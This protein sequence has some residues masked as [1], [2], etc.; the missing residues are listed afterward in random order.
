MTS[1]KQSTACITAWLAL[2]LLPGCGEAQERAKIE[3]EIE[4]RFEQQ[5]AN[6]NLVRQS[7]NVYPV[8][9]SET[10]TVKGKLPESLVKDA[11]VDLVDLKLLMRKV[12]FDPPIDGAAYLFFS[13]TEITN[14]MYAACLADTKQFRDDTAFEKGATFTMSTAAPSLQVRNPGSLWRKGKMPAG[15]EEHPVSYLSTAQGMDFCEWLN[16]RYELDGSFRLPTEQEWLFAAYGEK[17]FYPW[18]NEERNWTGPDTEPV[19][20]RPELKTP[21]GLYGMWGNV[22]ELVL[23]DSNGYGGKIKDKYNPMITKWQ[24]TSYSAADS[25]PERIE[26]RQDYWGYTHSADSRSDTWGFRIVF[27]PTEK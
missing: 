3:R 25:W 23:S 7:T 27:V 16:K 18:G 2:C 20:K 9:K 22:A 17:R 26:P 1:V 5:R 13:E 4:R 12:V 15:R 6:E 24:G 21:D 8:D 14:A 10:P 11:V 19:Q